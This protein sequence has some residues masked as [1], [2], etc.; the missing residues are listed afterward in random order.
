MLQ[1]FYLV[2]TITDNLLWAWI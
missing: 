2:I 1:T